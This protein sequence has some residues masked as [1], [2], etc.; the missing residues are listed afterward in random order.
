MAAAKQKD[1]NARVKDFVGR[2]KTMIDRDTEDLKESRA[3]SSG[4]GFSKR[5]RELRG[6]AKN[7]NSRAETTTNVTRP[8]YNS[9][10][11]SYNAN[12]FVIG[13]RRY[14][15]GDTF[16]VSSIIDYQVIKSD[17]ADVASKVLE[18]VL[19][20]G[21]GYF[22]V[23]TAYDNPSAQ[24]QY[25]RPVHLDNGRVFFDDC[26]S[27]TGSDCQ[28][29][30]Y[31]D[32]ILKETATEKYDISKRE[33]SR[34][35]DPFAEIDYIGKNSN[36]YTSIATIYEVTSQGCE[37][38]TMVHGQQVGK[39]V[40]FPGLTRLPIVR[41]AAE[42][43]F[44]ESEEQ[45]T[46]RGAYW[47]VYSL[48]KK[49]NYE[50][51]SQT[52]SVAT[53]PLTKF[54][55]PKG[56]FTGLS[57]QL[58]NVNQEPRLYIEYNSVDAAG[59]PIAA[60]TPY[61]ENAIQTG[62]MDDV[63]KTNAL[64]AAILG[65]PTA[66]SPANETAEAVLLKKGNQEATVSRFLKALKESLEEVG[67]V[68][69]DMLPSLYPADRIADGKMLQAVMDVDSYYIEIDKGPMVQSQQQRSI[70][71]LMALSSIIQANPTNPVIPLIIK[72]SELSQPDKDALMQS[73]QPQQ[74]QVPPEIQQQMAAKDQQ[75]AQMQQAM[76][77]SQKSV[78]Q[79]Q[80][81]LFEMQTDSKASMV[82]TQMRIASDERMMQMK[83]A[84]EKEKY[85]LELQAK[86]G[87]LS[88][89]S[90]EADKD[91]QLESEIAARDSMVE[92]EKE[93][94][95]TRREATKVQDPLFTASK[96]TT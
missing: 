54:L 34:N 27:P 58:S 9:V 42:K 84:W 87:K 31:I 61:G 6:N 90:L 48:V 81:A 19:N 17:L 43:I 30:V 20:D 10:I 74:S 52:E 8:W 59:Q 88:Y 68:M 22:L 94:E 77:E 75:I 47:F 49:I 57:D 63:E 70:A 60:P 67:R 46:Y 80:Q 32:L 92:L 82:Q 76:A 72:N 26:D 14:D 62:L 21:Y 50:M 11:S 38:S 3:F 37:V 85:L 91:R 78:A 28:M 79:L 13:V 40:L 35:S 95:Q 69:L 96:F 66:E 29:A 39:T 5:D 65:N 18:D 55:A 89:D 51:S 73:M 53:K 33:L 23:D 7:A 15:G 71:I 16:G 4:F 86:A 25:A 36:D 24:T 12:P 56:S 64:V 93:R 2:R 41:C 83:L 1:L 44:L 45:W